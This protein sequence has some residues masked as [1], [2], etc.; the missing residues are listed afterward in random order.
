MSRSTARFVSAGLVGLMCAAIWVFLIN[1]PAVDVVQ[2]AEEPSRQNPLRGAPEMVLAQS[3][4]SLNFSELN[5]PFSADSM[6]TEIAGLI[7]TDEYGHLIQDVELKAF[8]DYF[9]SSV[10]QVTPE[11][12]IRR[13]YLHANQALSEENAQALMKTLKDYLAFKEASIDLLAQPIDQMQ[14]ENSADYRLAQ[15]KYALTTLKQLRREYMDP[16]IAD[17]F[18]F[19]EEAYGDYTIATQ[20]LAMDDSLTEKERQQQR[21]LARDQLPERM[22]HIIT[23]QENRA[24]AL[25]GLQNLTQTSTDQNEIT[26]YIYQNFEGEE[27]QALVDHYQGEAQ[28]KSQFQR[29]RQEVDGLDKDSM[30]ESGYREAVAQLRESYFTEEQVSMVQAWDYG[31]VQD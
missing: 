3:R 21:M 28:L 13:I 14:V 16:V 31:L 19:E 5:E 1:E 7:R 11:Q 9:L 17:A 12:A 2:I 4:M 22:R 6:D 15:L 29:Y 30:T 24:S 8:F 18:F 20:S 25:Q 23:D 10:G 27:A 26:Q